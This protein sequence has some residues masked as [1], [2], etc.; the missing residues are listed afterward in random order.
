M[1]DATSNLP[2][3]TGESKLVLIEAKRG[4]LLNVC[5]RCIGSIIQ[6]NLSTVDTIGTQLAVLYKEVSIIQR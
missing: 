6:W 2:S 1:C 5:V 4:L 3:V